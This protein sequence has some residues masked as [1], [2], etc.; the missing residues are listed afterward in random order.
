MCFIV[1]GMQ[2][3]SLQECVGFIVTGMQVLCMN[4]VLFAARCSSLVV[5]FRVGI[6]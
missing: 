6:Y 5:V 4:S 3:L 2:V 1:T